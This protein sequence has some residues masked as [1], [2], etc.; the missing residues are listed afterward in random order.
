MTTGVFIHRQR[1]AQGSVTLQIRGI[2]HG[3]DVLTIGQV[4]ALASWGAAEG[5]GQSGNWLRVHHCT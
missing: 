1:A 3:R 4:D 5:T 2:W